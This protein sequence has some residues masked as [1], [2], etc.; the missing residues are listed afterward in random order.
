MNF[1]TKLHPRVQETNSVWSFLVGGQKISL[2][3]SEPET[4]VHKKTELNRCAKAKLPHLTADEKLC[5]SD[6]TLQFAFSVSPTP[7]PMLELRFSGVRKLKKNF[8]FTPEKPKIEFP[9]STDF[10]PQNFN[11]CGNDRKLNS[12][13]RK[14]RLWVEP[15]S[16]KTVAQIIFKLMNFFNQTKHYDIQMTLEAFS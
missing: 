9:P 6:G 5:L 3:G 11:F 8:F 13:T 2:T 16:N 4:I 14:L 1:K 10:S 7:M 15:S 12:E